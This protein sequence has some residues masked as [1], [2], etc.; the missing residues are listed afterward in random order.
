MVMSR[1]GRPMQRFLQEIVIPNA[2]MR[3]EARAVGGNSIRSRI[4]ILKKGFEQI[5]KK[6]NNE[7][8]R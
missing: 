3:D 4:Y 5:C 6:S 8:G 2:V 1:M 7:I